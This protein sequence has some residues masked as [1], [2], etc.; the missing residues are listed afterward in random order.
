MTMS[1]LSIKEELSLT[2]WSGMPVLP[3]AT[4]AMASVEVGRSFWKSRAGDLSG[5]TGFGARCMGVTVCVDSLS[6]LF[7][8][9]VAVVALLL[10]LSEPLSPPLPFLTAMFGVTLL[11]TSSPISSGECCRMSFASSVSNVAGWLSLSE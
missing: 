7:L 8:V 9:M 6:A 1:K 10:L 11:S 4:A 2:V 5:S 3:A